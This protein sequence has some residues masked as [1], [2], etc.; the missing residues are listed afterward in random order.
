[1]VTW[2]TQNQTLINQICIYAIAAASMQLAMSAGVFSLLSGATWLLGS[3]AAAITVREGG[4]TALAFIIAIAIGAGLGVLVSVVTSRVAGIGLAMVTISLVLITGLI[5]ESAGSFTGGAVGLFAIPVR[6]STGGVLA[7]AGAVAIVLTFVERGRTGR[8]IAA[9]R[10]DPHIA[11]SVGIPVARAR[12]IVMF[13]SGALAGL[14]GALYSFMFF[15]IT[16]TQGGFDF[17]VLLLSMVIV[18]GAGSWRGA[19][20]GAALLLW[21][22]NASSLANQWNGVVYGVLLISM[23][24]FAPGGLTGLIGRVGR[25]AYRKVS[26]LRPVVASRPEGEA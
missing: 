26:A 9:L 3:Y 14:S 20:L 8:A 17:V 24:V 4:G 7:F 15:T 6:V 18:G 22:P 16:P 12:H 1:M 13:A 19:Y 10:E 2:W 5:L 25:M 11:A 21:L 23:V